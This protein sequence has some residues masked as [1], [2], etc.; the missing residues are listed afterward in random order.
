MRFGG[1]IRVSSVGTRDRDRFLSPTLQRDRIE[2]WCKMGDHELVLVHEDIDVSGGKRD[3]AN[4]L[5]LV[6]RVEAGTLDGIIVARLDRF[7][8]N[9]VHATALMERID[10]AGGQFVSVADGF[11]TSTPYGR[12]ALNILLS[13]AQFELERFRDSWRESRSKMIEQ[14]R[15]YGPTPPIGYRRRADGIL[16][17]GGHADAIRELFRRRALGES[18]TALSRWLEQEGVRTGVGGRPVPRFITK[19]IRNRVY[20]GEAYA[21]DLVNP[22]AHEPLVDAITWRRANNAS[23]P[24]PQ[25]GPASALAGLVRC[26]GCRYVMGAAWTPYAGGVRK[27][28]YRCRG[29]HSLGDC[30]APASAVEDHLLPLVE[31]AFFARI[32]QMHATAAGDTAE[33]ARLQAECARASEALVTF[34]DDPAVIGALGP[35]AFAEGLRVRRAALD[36]AEVDLAREIARRPTG[37]PDAASLRMTWAEIDQDRRRKMLAAVFDAVVVQ[38]PLV[39]RSHTE[40]LVA[41]VRL[42]P[43]GSAGDIPRPGRRDFRP[44]AFPAFD[45]PAGAWIPLGEEVGED[46][47]DG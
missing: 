39:H 10:A 45:D 31:Q 12:L 47:R 17:P 23:A 16:E 6:Q 5:D 22:A 15:H 44:V 20:L 43:A 14:G 40:P 42:I 25:R 33:I 18:A 46:R 27:R 35:A 29:R 19:T 37:L 9:I 11:D 4:L 32:G 8:R 28:A 2:G 3:R 30:A 34:R 1:Y 41:R 26:H 36:R 7:A 21:G 24:Q 38:K 13:I